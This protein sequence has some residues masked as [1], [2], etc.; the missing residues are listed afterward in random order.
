MIEQINLAGS[1]TLPG[2]SITL[3]R[4]GYGAMQ[5][6]GRDGN[7]LVFPIALGCMAMSGISNP[8]QTKES[9][10]TT[11]EDTVPFMKTAPPEWLLA[12]WKEIDDKTFGKGFDC[13]AEDAVCNLGV[14]DWHGREA[15]R[16]NLKA[17]IDTGFTAHHDVVEYWDGGPLKVFRG[18]VTM[19]PDDPSKSTVKPSMAHF[20]YMD[21]NDPTK[22]SR[23][24]GAV[25]PVAF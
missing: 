16:K 9:S 19:R 13:F 5:L 1:F 7:K 4:M 11:Q 8:L 22:V 14:A 21:K 12:F 17:F 2:T 20:F 25:G 3:S 23:W 10:M 15:I 6:A 24:I 18:I